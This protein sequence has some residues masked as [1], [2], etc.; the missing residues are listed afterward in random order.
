MGGVGIDL[1]DLF[2][3][4]F[5]GFGGF[6]FSGNSSRRDPNAPVRG[7]DL[8]MIIEVSLLEAF[9]GVTKDID[10]VRWDT[11]ET[12]HGSGAKTGTQPETCPRCKGTGQIRR[13]Q[14]SI[15]GSMVTVSTCPDCRGSGKIIKEKCL[16]CDG[17]GKIHK[18]H[19]IE[20]KIRP[21]VERGTKLRVPGSGEAGKNGGSPGDLYLITDVKPN[22]NFE[23]DGADLHTRLI[24]TYPQAVLGTET[25]ILNL[26]NSKEKISVSAG[27]S[28][29][30]VLKIKGCGMPRLNNPKNRG[31]LYAHVFIDVPKKLTDKQKE[32]IEKLAA[33]MKTPVNVNETGVFDK[34]KNLFK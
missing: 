16:D 1:N 24:L 8:E 20:V 33:E 6:D 30:D 12:C 29:G 3:D 19:T 34:F 17:L 22:E 7:D 32:L 26:D 5:S 31:D 13:T 27:T 25:E 10:V 15:L 9:T 14:Q 28:Q 18:K 21:G 2:G 4:I 11:C 23:R